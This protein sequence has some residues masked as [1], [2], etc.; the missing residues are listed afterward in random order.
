MHGLL[1]PAPL[2]FDKLTTNGRRPSVRPSTGPGLPSINQMKA[3]VSSRN[4]FAAG[5]GSSSIAREIVEDLVGKR[6]E[7]GLR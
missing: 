7:E 3:T 4:L 1:F 5:S 2:W 6:I